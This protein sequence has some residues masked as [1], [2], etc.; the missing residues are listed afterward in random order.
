MY[1]DLADPE[2]AR[3]ESASFRTRLGLFCS[4][5]GLEGNTLETVWDHMASVSILLGWNPS[6]T[7]Q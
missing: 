3:T 2:L 1:A 6:E 4:L 7:L 5:L